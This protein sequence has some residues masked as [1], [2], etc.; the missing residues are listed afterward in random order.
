LRAAS[1]FR[2][3]SAKKLSDGLLVMRA[4]RAMSGDRT[5]ASS[6]AL[7]GVR[8]IRGARPTSMSRASRAASS[9]TA[10]KVGGE[11]WY[12]EPRSFAR[13]RLNASAL[14]GLRY[15]VG[16]KPVP[17]LPRS[18]SKTDSSP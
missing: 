17:G 9:R 10:A 18:E 4:R 3:I 2:S 14:M 12:A 15:V 6:S 7:A 1:P 16:R 8:P 5:E 13:P 11:D